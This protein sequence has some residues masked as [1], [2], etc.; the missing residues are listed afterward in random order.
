MRCFFFQITQ[1]TILDK[2][3][4]IHFTEMYTY[5]TVHKWVLSEQSYKSSKK[6]YF[7]V[8]CQNTKKQNGETNYWVKCVVKVY[9]AGFMKK[10][11]TNIYLPLTFVTF[12]LRKIF[13][14]NDIYLYYKFSIN[15]QVDKCFST[16]K[17][18][19]KCE[20]KQLLSQTWKC[21]LNKENMTFLNARFLHELLRMP[22]TQPI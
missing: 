10:Y 14:K 21:V 19:N 22:S 8:A 9:Y 12:L 6:L 20:M 16:W 13:K 3:W 18:H 1:V 5:H 7:S 17:T 11:W 4:Q 15:K 2:N